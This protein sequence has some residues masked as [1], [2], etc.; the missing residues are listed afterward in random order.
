MLEETGY[1][2]GIV[3]QPRT[4][5]NRGPRGDESEAGGK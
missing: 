3:N 2:G 1:T 5:K 4:D